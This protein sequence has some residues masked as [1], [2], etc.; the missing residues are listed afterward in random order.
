MHSFRQANWHTARKFSVVRLLSVQANELKC[1]NQQYPHVI[2]PVPVSF[3][4]KNET[5]YFDSQ[6]DAFFYLNAYR[7]TSVH[8]D[9]TQA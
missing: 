2:G 8:L 7:F 3:W 5:K 6:A 4:L 1:N 9:T